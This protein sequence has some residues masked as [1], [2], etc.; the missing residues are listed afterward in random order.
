MGY[1]WHPDIRRYKDDSGKVVPE[2]IIAEYINELTVAYAAELYNRTKRLIDEFGDE[3]FYT[4]GRE[5][6][7]E[8]NEL[9]TSIAIIALGG[10]QAALAVTQTNIEVWAEIE[11]GIVEQERYFDRFML[12]IVAGVVALSAGMSNRASLY[13][14]AGYA[15]YENAVRQREQFHGGYNEEKRII[16]SGKP[17]ITC[18]AQ[19]GLDWQPR[20]T[21]RR[22]GHSECGA[23]CRCRFLYR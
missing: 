4:W 5:T 6:R 20:G 21:L 3:A 2:R 19:A 13:G 18:V 12:G 16:G 22:I 17:C 9:H 8:L 15:T 10:Y 14:L 1:T 7:G 23:R 11:N